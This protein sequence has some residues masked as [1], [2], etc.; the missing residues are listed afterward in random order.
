MTARIGL[1]GAGWWATFNHIP[2]VQASPHADLV[3][4]CDLDANRVAEVGEAFAIPGRYTDLPAMLEL[5]QMLQML[6]HPL[7]LQQW[8]SQER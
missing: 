8:I 5:L 4:I 7:Q 2:T 3:A 1:V 6:L